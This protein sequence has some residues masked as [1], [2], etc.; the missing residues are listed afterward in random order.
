MPNLTVCDP[1]GGWPMT[2]TDDAPALIHAAPEPASL[3]EVAG[4]AVRERLAAGVRLLAA[5]RCSYAGLVMAVLSFSVSVTPSLLPRTWLVQGLVSGVSASM[6]YA[7]GVVIGWPARFAP[8]SWRPSERARRI[9]WG[10]LAVFA[11]AL[12]TVAVIAGSQWQRDMHTMMG[13]TPP[14]PTDYAGVLL[15]SV[16]VPVM[17]VALARLLRGA[18]RMVGRQ[19]G[20]WVPVPL[21]RLV[22]VAAVI[23]ASATLL[24]GIVYE[25]PMAVARDMFQTSNAER[26]LDQ[27]AP[28]SRLRSGGPGSLVSWQSLGMQGRRF[29]AGGPST[30][31]LSAFSG[32]PAQLPIRVYAG[33]ESGSISRSAE[34]AVGELRRTGAF[35]RAVLCVVTTT[36]TGWVDPNAAAALEYLYNG[37]TAMA[38]TQYSFVPSW[39]SFLTER[40]KVEQAGRELFSQVYRAWA[41]VPAPRRPKLL[42]FA[43]SLGSLGSEA[44]FANVADL[45]NRTDGVLWIGPTAVNPLRARL[46]AARAAGT[47]VVLPEYGDGV[48]V[49]FATSAGDL[50]GPRAQVVYLQ[51]ASDPVGWWS[52]SLLVKPPE[53]LK[54]RRGDD[55]LPAMRWYPL[56]TFLQVTADLSLAYTSPAGHGHRYDHLTAAAWAA[57]AAPPG[58]TAARTGELNRLLHR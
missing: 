25:R 20:R 50:A 9:A 49:R 31:Q 43:E 15:V 18:E 38:G 54:E 53:W 37:D 13:Q 56:V 26:G 16:L 10:T 23:G 52:P 29:V 55:V 12:V 44:A 3:G 32:R 27:P 41:A 40:D 1:A 46:T 22:A 39:M 48:D 21:A 6:G 30:K 11:A 28:V 17:L 51:N 5:C 4:R 35:G 45:E 14:P 19:L 24:Q 47:R 7:F 42:V 2:T 57:L 33:L 36:G 34:L 58:W 8:R